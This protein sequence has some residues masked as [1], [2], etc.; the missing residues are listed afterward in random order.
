MFAS[1]GIT[2]EFSTGMTCNPSGSHT[3]YQDLK[4]TY[5]MP[6]RFLIEAHTEQN[7]FIPLN[8]DLMLL[9]QSK[10]LRG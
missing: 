7:L 10:Q 2:M 1:T 9:P 8:V 5:C 3:F 4:F 6:K